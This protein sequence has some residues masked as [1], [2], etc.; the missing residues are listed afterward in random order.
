MDIPSMCR[1]LINRGI[2]S[3][4][5]QK[6]NVV[7]FPYVALFKLKLGQQGSLRSEILNWKSIEPFLLELIINH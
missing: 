1:K 6:V 4:P 7:L 3:S 2:F 5:N